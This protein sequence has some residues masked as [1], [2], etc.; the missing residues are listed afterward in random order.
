VAES[1]K[2]L[3]SVDWETNI[4]SKG[5]HLNRWPY[6]EVVS[7]LLRTT[8]GRNRSE[9]SVMEIGCGAGNNIWFLA[10]EGFQTHGLDISSTAIDHARR[11][12]HSVGLQAEFKVG[13]IAEL[14]WTDGMFDYVIDRGALTHNTHVEIGKSLK[15]VRRV[16]K[17]MGVLMS[18]TLFGMNHPDRQSGVEICH[19]TFDD[20]RDGYFRAIGL[21]SFFTREDLRSLFGSFSDTKLT[22]TT[23]HDEQDRILDEVFT[24][25]A[26]K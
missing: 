7:G 23:V 4:Y 18:F 8:S 13:D 11:R 26:V 22:R 2:H 21:T 3:S 25:I 17:P 5:N 19:H 16:L 24:V 10:A 14:P 6:D 9:V 12:L 15:E 20:F 1:A